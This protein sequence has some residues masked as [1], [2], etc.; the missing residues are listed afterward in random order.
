[1][2]TFQSGEAV[3]SKYVQFGTEAEF[4]PTVSNGQITITAVPEP[5]SYAAFTAITLIGVGVARRYRKHK[6]LLR[7]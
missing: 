6:R 5:E 3:D 2:A 7:A 1:M 4:F